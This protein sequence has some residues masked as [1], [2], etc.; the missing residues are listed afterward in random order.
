M[1][2]ADELKVLTDSIERLAAIEPPLHLPYSSQSSWYYEQ[3]RRTDAIQA[4]ITKL[5]STQPEPTAAQ[6]ER[7]RLGP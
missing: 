5:L 7:E 4:E 6:R 3:R 2:R 1:S